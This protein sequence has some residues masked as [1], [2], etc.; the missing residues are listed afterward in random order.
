MCRWHYSCSPDLIFSP[1][2]W[3]RCGPHDRDCSWWWPTVRERRIR[4]ILQTARPRWKSSNPSIGNAQIRYCVA[5]QNLG[6]DAR[7]TTG[8]DWVF[9]RVP[10]AIILEDDLVPDPSFFPW[11][12]AMLRRYRDEPKIMHV[13]GRNELGRWGSDSSDHLI[14]RRGSI[15]GWGAWR[16]A[17]FGVDREF[18][19]NE[20]VH[21]ALDRLACEPLLAADLD[22]LLNLATSGRIRAWDITWDLGKALAGGLSVIPPVNSCRKRRF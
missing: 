10:E 18:C 17:W 3:L 4:R 16:R 15:S 13:S 8:L 9:G 7:L 22:I 21:N 5:E 12:A 1:K 2:S 11:C 14:V 20:A 19:A 6:C